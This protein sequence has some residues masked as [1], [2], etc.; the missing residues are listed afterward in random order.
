VLAQAVGATAVSCPRQGSRV[1][2][3]KNFATVLAEI[4]AR[5]APGK[6]IEIWFQM[7]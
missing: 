1:G 7:L 6:P 5:E 3:Q 4:A 2:V